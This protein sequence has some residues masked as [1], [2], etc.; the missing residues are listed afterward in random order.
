[1]KEQY[2]SAEVESASGLAARVWDLADLYPSADDPS[3]LEGLVTAQRMAEEFAAKYRG[4]INQPDSNAAVLLEALKQYE[5]IHE[6]GL[7]PLFFA[8][9]DQAGDTQ[10]E[11]R[12]GLL[13]KV[14]ETW[15]DVSQQLVF[16]PLEIMSLPADT[17]K[18]LTY[19]PELQAYHHFLQTL[20]AQ[21][22]HHLTEAEEKIINTKD[23]SGRTAFTS[24]FTELMGS[25]TFPLEVDGQVKDLTSAEILAL[26]YR[27][28]GSLRERAYRT[29]MDG[30]AQHSLVFKNIINA[31]LLDHGLDGKQ[32]GYRTP[33]SKSALDNELDEDVINTMMA[34]TEQHYPLAQRYYRLKA[35]LLGLP[36]L[37]NTDLYAPIETPGEPIGFDQAR[38]L[39]L[40][41]MA[42]FHPVFHQS[43]Q[44]F[45]D[46][47]WIDADLRKG[48]RQGAFC[49]CYFPSHHP[50]I[51][52]NYTGNLRDVMTLAHELGHGIH[53]LLAAG[54]TFL[55]FSPPLV[56]AETAS[57]LNEL[58]LTRSLLAKPEFKD[59]VKGLLA[60]KIEDIT[61][62]VFRQNVLTRFEQA[63]H[64]LRQDHLLGTDEICDAWWQ[65][66]AKLYGSEVEMIPS[67]RWG[68]TYIPHFI[69][70][71]FYCY[72]YVFGQ[73]TSLA[74]YQALL[75]QGPDF[76]DKIIH[77]LSLGGSRAPR[78]ILSDLGWDPADPAFWT[79]GFTYLENLIDELERR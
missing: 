2:L 12:T 73:L 34:V 46:R 1:M 59:Q 55:N 16:F 23:L 14:R 28:D 29:F 47:N 27:P 30:V 3:L 8:S 52:M 15:H 36:K 7:R 4:Q 51:L 56:L 18:L 44:K 42:G 41:A 25:L 69:H 54:Q 49:S 70:Y 48:K 22:P 26:L 11:K 6:T 45:F 53:D 66:N 62:T 61:A 13:Q 38:E 37:K 43:A 35:G 19:H 9:L 63:I 31:L 58:A 64:G 74:L 20:L 68:W 78:Q 17:L 40:E 75:D 77:L 67:Y 50:Y 39:V 71:H 5:A 57:I 24:L 21:K 79:Q 65:A 32:R 76:I 33:M 72:S 60:A 10:D